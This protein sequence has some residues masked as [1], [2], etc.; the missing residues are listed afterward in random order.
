[1]YWLLIREPEVDSPVQNGPF[2]ILDV[3]DKDHMFELVK[4]LKQIH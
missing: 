3:T 2:E 1:M 4:T